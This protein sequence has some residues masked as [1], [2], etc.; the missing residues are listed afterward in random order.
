VN[1]RS[2]HR[3]LFD[4]VRTVLNAHDPEGLLAVGGPE[5]EYTLEVDDFVRRLRNGQPISR[6]VVIDVW[7][8]WF[9]PNSGYVMRATNAELDKLAADLDALR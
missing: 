1:L 3:P 6:Q 8:G 7:E 4:E 5:D 9:G 2:D